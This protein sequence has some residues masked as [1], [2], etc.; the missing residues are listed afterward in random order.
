VSSQGT[1][2][3]DRWVARLT[4]TA[5]TTLEALIDL[6]LGLDVWQRG[7]DE[8]VVAATAAQLDELER[9]RLA[10]VERLGTAAEYVARQRGT[11]GG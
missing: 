7:A 4:P 3:P 9:R 6:P 11:A 2:R 5:S 8:L 1:E 10:H